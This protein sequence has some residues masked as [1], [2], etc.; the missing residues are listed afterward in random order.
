MSDFVKLEHTLGFK[1]NNPELYREAMTH[2]SFASE[3][4]LSYD[5]QRLEFLGDAVVQITVTDYLYKRYPSLQEGDLSKIRSAMAD[6]NALALFARTISLGSFLLLGRGEIELHGEDRDS[7]ICDA[8]ESLIAAIYLDQGLDTA[9]KFFLDIMEK[10]YPDP[11]S[12]LTEINPKGL[13]QEYTQERGMSVPAY[14]VVNVS[15]PDHEPC[16]EVE[17]LIQNKVVA[18]ASAGSRRLAEKEAAKIVLQQI[19]AGEITLGKENH[20]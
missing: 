17:V 9:R 10:I 7:T 18:K 5:N 6:Q 20:E 12:T 8:F 19:H 14:R 4:N 1:F 16:F 11:K 15:G 13:L 3:H 2:T